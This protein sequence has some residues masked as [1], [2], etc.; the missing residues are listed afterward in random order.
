M[1]ARRYR[2]YVVPLIKSLLL[3][4]WITV[5]VLLAEWTLSR[6]APQTL[7]TPMFKADQEYGVTLIPNQVVLHQ[8]AD[9]K[10][11]YRVNELGYRGEK[12]LPV[13]N[14]KARIVLVGDSFCFGIG[15]ED[16]QTFA[17][18]LQRAIPNA[19]VVNLGVP[20]WG[21]AQELRR[22]EREGLAY[23]PDVVILAF[24]SND[25]DDDQLSKLYDLRNGVAVWQGAPRI[26]DNKIKQFLDDSRSYRWLASH[27]QMVGLVRNLYVNA[28]GSTSEIQR[29]IETRDDLHYTLTEKLLDCFRELARVHGF[30]LIILNVADISSLY[31]NVG[32]PAGFL[33]WYCHVHSVDCV[34]SIPYLSDALHRAAGN[35]NLQP[36]FSHDLHWRATVHAWAAHQIAAK[37]LE[38]EIQRNLP[39]YG[40]G[41]ATR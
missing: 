31:E 4:F 10:V 21:T 12:I 35:A 37:V 29:K 33:M 13:P 22:L 3:A 41:V 36:F 11:T 19:D 27:S 39:K 23:R 18:G 9:F 20:G 6:Y 25:P 38:F 16:D 28:S 17:A 24:F 15:V 7:V 1:R 32:S 34:D 5:A 30:H 40:T 2:G 14:G 26:R 8:T